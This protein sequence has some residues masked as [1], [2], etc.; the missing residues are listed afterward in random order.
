[1]SF[2]ISSLSLVS[3]FAG[4]FSLAADWRFEFAAFSLA[5][6]DWRLDA[7]EDFP[8]A[9]A[10]AFFSFLALLVFAFVEAATFLSP[11]ARFSFTFFLAS[12][13]PAVFLFA[14]AFCLIL[15]LVDLAPFAWP[16]LRDDF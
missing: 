15:S 16:L 11:L 7:P 3:V 2:D 1:M 6:I 9:L 14:L 10:L 8:L 5:V 12:E 13:L 4:V